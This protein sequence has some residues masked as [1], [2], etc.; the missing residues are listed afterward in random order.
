MRNY[1]LLS[2]LLVFISSLSFAQSTI[3]LVS[4]N[5]ELT[6]IKATVTDH[7]L[8][9]VITPK[10]QAFIVSSGSATPILQAGMPD[11]PK[12]T[13]SIII[14]NAEMMEVGKVTY[15]GYTDYENIDIAPSKGNFTRDIS[16]SDVPYTYREAYETD[17]FWPAKLAEMRDPYILRDFRGQTVLIYP[18]QYNPVTKTLRV[19][20]DITVSLKPKGQVG[21]NRKIDAGSKPNANFKDIYSRHFLNFDAMQAKYDAVEEYGNMLII[22]HPGFMDAMA[23]FIQWKKQCGIAVEMVDVSD[24]GNNASAI[25]SY[26]ANYYNQKGLTYLLLVGDAPN[27]VVSSSTWA[28]DSDN[29]YAYVEGNDSYPEFFVGRFSAET[30]GHVNTMVERVLRYEKYPVETSSHFNNGICI[31]SAEGPGDDG[32][33][34]FEHER[35]IRTDLIAFTY[36][37]VYELYDGTQGGEDKPGDPSSADFF[38]LLQNGASVINY[39]GHG[40][41]SSCGTTG[42]NSNHVDQLTNVDRYPFFF[43]VA[44]VNGEFVGQ[45]CFA[46]QW[47]RATDDVTG[48]PTGA[49]A[50]L[51]ATINQSWNPPMCGQDEMNDILS[52]VNPNNIKRTFGAIAMNGCM[53]MND[54]YGIDG[55]EMTDTWTLFGDPSVTVRTDVPVSMNVSHVLTDFI[56][57][58]EV[59]ITCDLDGAIITIM[60]EGEVIGSGVVNNGT[61]TISFD[62]INQLDTLYVTATAFNAMPYFGEVEIVGISV[63]APDNSSFGF[64]VDLYPNPTNGELNLAIE[65]SKESDIAIVVMNVAGAQVMEFPVLQARSGRN[66][67]SLDLSG[68]SQGVYFL[69]LDNGVESVTR[70]IVIN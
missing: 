63:N 34:D 55:D 31:G 24:I 39:T 12:L 37:T 43:S 7:N 52:E 19:Y 64:G 57:T 36:D 2:T 18:F 54:D 5:D 50:T 40:S 59:V 22:S 48:E 28:G 65:L 8:N 14:P 29:D 4:Q 17:E 16:P 45:D 25:K 32:E 1:K 27:Y 42:L 44:C 66:L 30:V 6:K 10:G 21:I 35:N 23:P 51:M 3:E 11:L 62:A 69:R 38:N 46:E 49:I 15:S 60:N 58:D 68:L 33:M 9:A 61:V 47:L 41:S 56:G 53:Q 13:S 67:S 26:V 70:K 20:N